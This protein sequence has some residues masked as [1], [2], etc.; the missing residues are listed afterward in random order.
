MKIRFGNVEFFPP[1]WTF[2]FMHYKKYTIG[3]S[4]V[5]TILAL[6]V[7]AIRGINYS[8]D[9]LGG[10]EVALEVK[11][12]GVTR[13][14]VAEAAAKAGVGE[15]EV[16]TYGALA[17]TSDNSEFLVRMQHAKDRPESETAGRVEKVI[18]SVRTDLGADKVEV[19]S[20][21]N[22]SGK[23]GAEEERKGYTALLLACLGILIYIAFRFDPRFGPGAIICLVHD[24]IIA[25][26]FMTALG[27]P[28]STSS[29]AAF[30]TII[31]Y[32]INDTVIVYDRIREN[33]TLNPRMP[34]NDVIN[35]SISQTMN[36]TVLTA[37]TGLAALLVFA[38]LG[39]GAIE[40]FAIT[41][42]VGIVVGTY[43]SIYVAAPLTIV[44]ENVLRRFGWEP[45][46]R[47]KAKV[48]KD[49]NYIPPVV[50]KKKTSTK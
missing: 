30:L 39:G 14:R 35:V 33:Q 50:L 46:D 16:T 38:A 42:F 17:S 4:V 23:I 44:M 12:R 32:S 41:M 5:L 20:I 10:A 31:G 45:K 22:I 28:F 15:V 29:I 19:K 2:D 36:R 49:P 13:E 25:L 21:A 48:A 9:F 37:S 3:L 27:K 40:D 34:I 18:E 11:E 1:N 6:G 7:I 43:S 47:S 26:G 8:I 24:V